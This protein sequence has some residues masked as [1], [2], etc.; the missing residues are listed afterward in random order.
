VFIQS[1]FKLV[2]MDG[3]F[4]IVVKTL[5]GLEGVLAEEIREL[6]ADNIAKGKRMVSF[7]GDN[8]LLYKANYRLRTALRVLKPI[9]KFRAANPDEVYNAVK[10][11]PWE[12][13]IVDKQTFSIDAVV[14]SEIFTHSK[15]V[16]Y[17]VKDAI[18]DYFTERFG[19][20][21]SV[22]V[23]NPDIYINVHIS[24]DNCTISL[25]SS[26]ESLHRRGYRSSQGEAP[27]SEVLAAGM[28]LLTG[29]KGETNL[30]DPM[31]GSGT[32][33]TE[34]AM[35]ALNIPPGMYRSEYAFEKWNDFD[36]ELF[37]SITEDDSGEREFHF[38]CYGSDIS[39][40][41]IDKALK[42][43]AGASL[44]KYIELNVKSMQHITDPPQPGLL[45]MNPPYGERISPKD[46]FELYSM[47]GE[48]LKHAFMGYNAWI[49]SHKDECFD[50]IGLHPKQRIKL[51]NGEL[52][53]EFRCY[54]MF[55]GK[56]KFTSKKQ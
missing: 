13:Y 17:R 15:F 51:M 8:A 42:N 26:G 1:S 25:D 4:E 45:V 7:T 27:L 37:E 5:F 33:L 14:Y 12:K 40:L 34:A 47:I 53:C 2:R 46:I 28:I 9:K 43:V 50:A 54:E 49:I 56:K 35:I 30:I 21:P 24:H 39:P 48:R 20:R 38:K 32:L 31:C 41:A 3:K 52:E 44:S 19:K 10:K 22:R 29:W 18:A 36:R 11:I 16:A 23:I 55:V 6:G